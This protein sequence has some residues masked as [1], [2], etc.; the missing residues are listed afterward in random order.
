MR[1][2]Q[3]TQDRTFYLFS[4]ESS[5]VGPLDNDVTVIDVH[6]LL[7]LDS[8]A[9]LL[10]RFLLAHNSTYSLLAVN[11]F[12]QLFLLKKFILIYDKAFKFDFY[13]PHTQLCQSK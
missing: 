9:P 8:L 2:R 6:A 1:K 3:T 4:G 13:I 11:N 7:Q 5:G 12:L 10:R